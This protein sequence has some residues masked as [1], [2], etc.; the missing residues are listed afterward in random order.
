MRTRAPNLF[1]FGAMVSD[2]P[3]VLG[4]RPQNENLHLDECSELV[5][6]PYFL[7]TD[8]QHQAGRLFR[9]IFHTSL[10]RKALMSGRGVEGLGKGQRGEGAA[11]VGGG[12][13][14]I[15][16]GGVIHPWEPPRNQ[17]D[18][19]V[20]GNPFYAETLAH[21]TFGKGKDAGARVKGKPNESANNSNNPNNKGQGGKK[22]GS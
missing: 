14:S 15:G 18:S 16:L 9:I 17:E 13:A 10:C 7:Q 19:Q 1:V 12:G 8:T 21:K 20:N 4:L 22:G 5:Q 6:F 3:T 11:I 2:G